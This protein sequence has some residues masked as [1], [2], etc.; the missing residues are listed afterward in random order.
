[1]K[2]FIT[3]GNKYIRKAMSECVGCQQ[4][5]EQFFLKIQLSLGQTIVRK[6]NAMKVKVAVARKI[7]VAI[8]HALAENKSYINYKK[9]SIMGNS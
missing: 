1:M 5:I 7:L 3:A 4:N 8:S 9:P 2:M 6:K